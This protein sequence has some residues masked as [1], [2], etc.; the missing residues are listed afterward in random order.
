MTSMN[1]TEKAAKNVIAAPVERKNP[2]TASNTSPIKVWAVVGGAVLTFIAWVLFRWITGPYFTPVPSGPSVP[3]SW[4]KANLI[5]W[6]IISPV[7]ALALIYWFIVKPWIRKR[8]IGT[9]GVFVAAFCS[10]WFQ[11]PL[12]NYAG[13]WVTYNS[14]MFNMGSWHASVPGSVSFAAPGAMLAEPL[15]L[16]PPLYVYFFWLA[17]LGG[18]WVMKSVAANMPNAGKGT[19]IGACFLAVLIFDFVLEG[20]IWMP[21]GAWSLPGGHLPL[22]FPGTYHQF[23][24]NEF[25]PVSLTLT[26]VAVLYYFRD[27]RGLTFA[28]RGLEK[29]S[30]SNNLRFALRTLATTGAVHA[31]MFAC[32]TTPNLIFAMNAQPWPEDVQKRSYFTNYICGDGTD[33]ACPGPSVPNLRNNNGVGRSGSAYITPDGKLEFP[34]DSPRPKFVPFDSK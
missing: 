30:L 2:A 18:A 32:Y 12:C 7:G 10:L 22:L 11:D 17:C 34:A 33:R 1:A 6:Q 14:W 15:L 26:A 24:I 3:P 25:V 4:M 28:E 27:D 23:T 8:D 13:S 9:D 31:L 21:G 5:F 29:L 20:L 16:I 19:L